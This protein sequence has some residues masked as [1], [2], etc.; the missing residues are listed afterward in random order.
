M[1][2]FYTLLVAL[3]IG[4]TVI[5]AQNET[6]SLTGTIIDNK[7][8]EAIEDVSIRILSLPDS[9][10]IGST[11]TDTKGNFSVSNLKTGKYIAVISF[12]GY[13]A[14]KIPFYL[15]AMSPTFSAGKIG[16]SNNAILLKEA[17]VTG[18]AIQVV[19]KISQ[20]VITVSSK[21]ERTFFKSL[22]QILYNLWRRSQF[23]HIIF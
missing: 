19:V 9:T 23:G 1:K 20:I 6:K 8:Q 15:T 11:T 13:N 12:L 4:Y 10:F 3:S 22:R 7:K 2:R 21:K 16:L 5:H 18:K 17:V 14:K